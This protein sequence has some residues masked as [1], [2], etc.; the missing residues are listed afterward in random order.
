MDV[1]REK[2]N[3]IEIRFAAKSNFV[4]G[5]YNAPLRFSVI[6]YM[7]KHYVTVIILTLMSLSTT[8][9]FNAGYIY[10]QE[11]PVLA[12]GDSLNMA[13]AG[14]LNN[15]QYSPMN[16]TAGEEMELFAFDRDGALRKGFKYNSS[17]KKLEWM[18]IIP[19][20]SVLF[21]KHFPKLYDRGFCLMRDFDGDGK[22]DIF[23]TYNFDG[24]SI[25]R[26]VGNDVPEFELEVQQTK[27][28]LGS[29]NLALR[30]ARNTLPV[31]KDLDADGDL[32]LMFF[33]VNYADICSFSTFTN[34][35]VEA[36]GN[37]DSLEFKLDN[38]CWGEIRVSGGSHPV[39]NWRGFSCDTTCNIFDNQ[40]HKDITMTQNL[41]DLD[42]DGVQD[43]LI[44]YDHYDELYGMYNSNTTTEGVIDQSLND[45]AFPSNDVQVKLH[46]QPYPFFIDI[47]HD[48]DDDMLVS[49]IQI[50]NVDQNEFDTS[51]AVI[52][53][54]YY[55]NVGSNSNPIFEF[56]KAGYVSGEMVD[57]GIGSMPC[58]GDLNGDTLPD[59]IVGNIGYNN[60]ND[61]LSSAKLSYYENVGTK[62]NP[63]FQLVDTDFANVSQLGLKSAHPT[64]GDIDGDGDT[65]LLVG[66]HTGHIQFYKNI[67]FAT[68]YQ[69][70]LIPN[71]EQ[72][73]VGGKA[74]PQLIDLSTDGLPDIV[75]GDEYGRIQ[76][77]E[78][79]GTLGNP[80][81]S[82][83]PTV[84]DMGAINIWSEF[85]GQAVPHFTRNIDHSSD[86]Y[87]LVGS[88]EGRIN[89][90]GPIT[91]ITDTFDLVDSIIV[92]A[93]ETAITGVDL[94]GDDQQ[95]LFIGQRAGGIYLL[96]KKK[97]TGIGFKE[98]DNDDQNL[99]VFPNPTSG[100]VQIQL[101]ATS[102]NTAMLSV[103]DI[104]GRVMLE[105]PIKANGTYFTD[106]IDLRSYPKGVYIVSVLENESYTW[107]KLIKE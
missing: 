24:M 16:F 94:M 74:H 9:Q 107:A 17:T 35:S 40:R 93:N 79:K 81:F 106:K 101:P 102:Q 4:F 46:N 78:N 52:S 76:Y 70:N 29:N 51:D 1:K 26:N 85:G 23:S 75:A 99:Q 42:G 47:D 22:A 5:M 65:D 14:G 34:Q 96:E 98:L 58:F 69:F 83:D 37:A 49:A 89:I 64:L 90:Y 28:Q 2:S 50:N 104:Q 100:F 82:S 55:E 10:S 66:D 59:M 13:W 62:G 63:V 27:Y 91:D 15:A 61:Q 44:T 60:F 38:K 20:D 36:Y 67:G 54:L 43:L 72:I 97:Q 92:E 45:N 77:F 31:I 95:E 68:S 33:P 105:K 84:E 7:F 32:D 48:G 71:Y 8:A 12:G 39:H 3:F 103:R 80:D 88:T 56:Q 11:I 73:D 87:L 30:F 86:L 18:P 6:I 53:D 25:H 21:E 41:H 19:E 57:V